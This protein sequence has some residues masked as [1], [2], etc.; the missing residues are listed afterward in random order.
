MNTLKQWWHILFDSRYFDWCT[1]KIMHVWVSWHPYIGLN[2][3]FSFEFTPAHTAEIRGGEEMS[4]G[5]EFRFSFGL[6]WID[7]GFNIPN[8]DHPDNDVKMPPRYC[9]KC[10]IE[11]EATIA[12]RCPGCA[13]LAVACTCTPGLLVGSDTVLY[14]T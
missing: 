12:D 8:D 9:P 2:F 4:W 6:P 11:T 13:K 5:A 10:H 3:D 14:K 7:I 1:S